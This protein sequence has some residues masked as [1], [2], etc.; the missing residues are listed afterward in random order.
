[1]TSAAAVW[2]ARQYSGFC[3]L[4]RTPSNEAFTQ[5]YVS[6]LYRAAPQY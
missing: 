1:M 3:G 4:F 5:K 2:V 6:S